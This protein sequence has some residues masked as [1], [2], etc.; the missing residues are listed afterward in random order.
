[1]GIRPVGDRAILVELPGLEEVLSLQAFLT[2]RPDQGQLDVVAAAETV[3]ITAVSTAAAA[4]IARTVWEADLS[5]PP[6]RDDAVVVIE[7][8]YD[9]EDLAVA[10]AMAGLTPEGLVG[11]HSQ[12]LW[13]AAFAGFAPGFAYLVSAVAYPPIPRR[14]SP[15]TSVPAGTVAMAGRYSA[16]YP[17]ISPGGWQLIGRTTAPIWD[18]T[19]QSPALVNPGNRVQFSPVRETAAMRRRRRTTAATPAGV[20]VRAAGLQTTVQDLGREG[21]ADIGVTGSGALDRAALRR[22]NRLVG[23]APGDAALET[24]LGGLELE[25]R[26]DQVLAVTG[27]P[28]P[29]TISAATGEDRKQ[30]SESPFALMAGERLTLGRPASGFRSYVAFRGGLDLPLVVSSRSTDLLSGTGSSPVVAGT[31]L[32]VGRPSPHNVV[33]NPE[34]PPPPPP[35]ITTFRYVPGPRTDWFSPE[36]AASFAEQVWTV[37]PS[38]NRIGLRL[39]GEA[40]ER[41]RTGEL[42]SE[43][44]VNGTIQVPPSGLPVLFLADHPVT[45]GYPVIG[46]VIGDDLDQAAQL[47][48]GAKLRF[49]AVPD[50][51]P[52]PVT[53]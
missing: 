6:E 16:V 45:G 32:P 34:T 21:F 15:R 31:A 10:A 42:T 12:Q 20:V 50:A 27:A 25:A 29:L 5:T 8:V 1:M 38:S 2:E 11:M 44:T 13:T 24:V 19:R 4:R 37:S 7:T 18:P 33:G 3:L 47:A 26:Q 43:G 51:G 22:A 35:D 40:L 17:G 28:A 53:P 39:L 52:V 46:V 9:G 36:S 14:P 41:A 48:P 23:N 30:S 49:L